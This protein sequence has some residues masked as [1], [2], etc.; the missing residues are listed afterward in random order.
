VAQ[1]HKEQVLARFKSIEGHVRGVSRMVE[2][3]AYCIDVIKQTLAII[4]AVEKV[5]LM[6]LDNHL[7][8]CVT[9]A[10]RGENPADRE[11]VL[12]EL[13]EVFETSGKL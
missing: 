12:T 5:N 1:N 13:L 9:T 8:T 4:K 7:N 11:R 6:I 2:E 10:I 3:D